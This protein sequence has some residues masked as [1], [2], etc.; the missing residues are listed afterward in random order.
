M[1][2]G[3]VKYLLASAG[4]GFL[5]VRRELLGGLLPT[6]TGWF[7]DEDIFKMDISDYSPAADARRFDTGTPPVPNIYAG[8]AGLSIILEAGAAVIEAHVQ[9]LAGEL[10]DGLDVL[11]AKVVTPSRSRRRA[12]RSSACASM[13]VDTLVAALGAERIVASSRDGNLRIALHLYNTREDVETRCSQRSRGT[14]TC[15]PET[16]ART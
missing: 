1:T 11:G 2:G 15:L 13:D 9:R 6:Q 5:Y 8:V 16:R 7:A 4:L 14:A 12:A 3:T 10:I